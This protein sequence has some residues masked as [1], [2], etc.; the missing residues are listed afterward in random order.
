VA[1]SEV[2]KLLITNAEII[3]LC[4]CAHITGSDVII[5]L[6]QIHYLINIFPN[7]MALLNKNSVELASKKVYLKPDGLWKK[8]MM[9][10]NSS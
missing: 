6:I 7:Q 5:L 1:Q 9:K 8:L 10:Y 4:E 2:T 3:F